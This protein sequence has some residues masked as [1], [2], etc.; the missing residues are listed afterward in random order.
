[1]E[2]P[3]FHSIAWCHLPHENAGEN[4]ETILTEQNETGAVKMLSDM[5]SLHRH[6]N[7]I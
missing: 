2:C 5:D 7:Q 3:F 1:M 6:H 4:G